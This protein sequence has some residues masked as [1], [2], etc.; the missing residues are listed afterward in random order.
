M[1]PPLSRRT[2]RAFTLIELLVVIAIIAILIGLLLPAVQKVRE[3]AAR[4]K[5][6][7]NLKQIGLALHNY[8]DAYGHFPSGHVELQNA[9]GAYIYYSCWSIDILPFIE[10]NNLYRT[11]LDNPVSNEDQRNQTFCRTFVNIYMCPS[12]MRFNL[13]LPPETL[14]PNGGGNNGSVQYAASSYRAMTGIGDTKTTDTYG[15]YWN[16]VQIAMKANLGGKGAFHGDGS[17]GLGP[18]RVANIQDGTSNT[19]FVGERHTKTHFTRGPFW[20]DSFNLYSKGAAWPYSAT[21]LPDYDL[22]TKHVSNANYCKYG[23]GSLH[24]GGI[25]F[26]FGDGSVRMLFKN[27]DMRTFMALSTIGGGEILPD[28]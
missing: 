6:F 19:L 12:D 15:G 14:A 27:I 11:Y 10:Q 18:E 17:S 13:V 25:S 24:D 20:A 3:A 23:W 16:E 2:R 8:H 22:C 9:A 4:T 26:L 21:M 7:N 1:S 28:F 5:C